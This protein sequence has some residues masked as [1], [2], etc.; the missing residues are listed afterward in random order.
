MI[1][2]FGQLWFS[3]L[4]PYACL[5]LLTAVPG[6]LNEFVRMLRQRENSREH[7]SRGHPYGLSSRKSWRLFFQNV[8]CRVEYRYSLLEYKFVFN[9]LFGRE[10]LGCC[11][12]SLFCIN[13][14]ETH[15]GNTTGRNTDVSLASDG[16]RRKHAVALTWKKLLF[17]ES[18]LWKNHRTFGPDFKV[19]RCVCSTPKLQYLAERICANQIIRGS[20]KQYR[21]YNE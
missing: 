8:S 10:I 5:M 12:L 7:C 11:L 13:R 17:H 2:G 16:V 19:C 20:T 6:M 18:S 9:A 14:T 21:K 3:F 15:S 1:A 4:P